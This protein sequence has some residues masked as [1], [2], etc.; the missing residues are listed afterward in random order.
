MLDTKRILLIISGGIA[1]YKVLDLIRLLRRDGADVRCILTQG[2]EKFVTPLSVAALSENHAYTD[3]WSLKDETEMGHIRLSRDVDL[4]VVAPASADFIAK[5]AHG[6]A[7]DLAS[8]TLLATTKPVL[9]APA[10]NPAMWNHDAT[11][12]NVATLKS[13]GIQLSGPDYGVMACGDTGYGRLNE[14][15]V[16]LDDIRQFF[17]PRPLKGKTALVTSGA[18][19]EPLD[20]VRFIG[21]RSSGKQGHAIATALAEAGADVTYITGVSA[22][23]P[24]PHVK[25]VNI[26][27]AQEMLNACENAL[28]AADIAICAAAVS[29]WQADHIADRKNKKTDDTAH[30]T[31]TFK[32][33]PDILKTIA[34]HPQHRPDLV[35]GFAAETDN[36]TRYIT[37]KREKKS[38]DW[39]LGNYVGKDEDGAERAFGTEDNIIYFNDGE[40]ITEWP[41]LSKKEIATRLTHHI[42]TFFDKKNT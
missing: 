2:G 7:N 19:Y 16:I 38:C 5:M 20:P 11:Q 24:P 25:T 3:L 23:A 29:D 34:Q 12:A 33:T 36:I 41:R 1:A 9:V 8:T 42:I 6:L 13:R 21:N 14:P 10:M 17:C 28:P 32:K 27:T 26:E 39:I 18:T 31:L 35:I 30:L 37:E 4:I 15:D 22:L 40:T